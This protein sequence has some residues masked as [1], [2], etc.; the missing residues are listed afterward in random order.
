NRQGKI[1]PLELW[2]FLLMPLLGMLV[3]GVIF[4][5]LNPAVLKYV[6]YWMLAGLVWYAIITKGFRK[7]VQMKIEE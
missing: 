6:S 5:S 1:G 4:I 3:I 7:I 2:R